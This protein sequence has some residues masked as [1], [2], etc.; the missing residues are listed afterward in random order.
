M[1]IKYF[2]RLS[3]QPYKTKKKKKKKK[4]TTKMC[5]KRYKVNATLDNHNKKKKI[6]NS[7]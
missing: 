1:H 4:N 3:L 6:L 5:I 2:I 7:T